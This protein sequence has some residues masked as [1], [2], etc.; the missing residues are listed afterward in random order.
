MI[1]SFPYQKREKGEEGEEREMRVIKERRRSFE[2]SDEKRQ[3][4][5]E[6]KGRE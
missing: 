3:G 4:L 1:E 5:K 6:N 2:E